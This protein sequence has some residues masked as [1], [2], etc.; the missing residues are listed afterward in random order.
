MAVQHISQHLLGGSDG[1][2]QGSVC[3][4]KG[5]TN[6]FA[7]ETDLETASIPSPLSLSPFANEETC[8][9]RKAAYHRPD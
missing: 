6:Y 2:E 7:E 5:K 9:R 4:F 8:Q 1:S 3:C